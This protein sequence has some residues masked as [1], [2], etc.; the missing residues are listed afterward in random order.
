MNRK[1]PGEYQSLSSMSVISLQVGM[2]GWSKCKD[3]KHNLLCGICIWFHSPRP[4]GKQSCWISKHFERI[5]NIQTKALSCD[6]SLSYFRQEWCFFYVPF[7]PAESHWQKKKK[8]QFCPS[9]NVYFLT[10]GYESTKANI[11]H[12]IKYGLRHSAE[13]TAVW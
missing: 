6:F 12:E 13:Y 3:H 1:L 4:L 7:C 10:H 9:L 2:M 11:L 5:H 8:T